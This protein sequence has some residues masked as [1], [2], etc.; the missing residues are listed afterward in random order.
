M[1]AKSFRR[2]EKQAARGFRGDPIGTVAFYGP[3]NEL[4]SKVVAAVV[5]HADSR[6]DIL[7]KWFSE[8]EDIRSNEAVGEASEPL[9][10]SEVFA[11]W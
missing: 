6:A 10:R 11:T 9:S 7:G 1:R 2:L 3:T 8:R 4:A 5:G